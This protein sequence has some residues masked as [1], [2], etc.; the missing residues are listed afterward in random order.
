MKQGKPQEYG[1]I[2]NDTFRT[3]ATDRNYTTV[4]EEDSLI[5]V[6]CAFAWSTQGKK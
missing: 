4:V 3:M 1:K 5:R 6:L 2:R